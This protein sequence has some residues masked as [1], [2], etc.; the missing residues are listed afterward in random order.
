ME[1]LHQAIK[2]KKWDIR[3]I[4]KNLS[5][6]IISQN[7][8]ENQLQSLPDASAYAEQLNIDEL[9]EKIK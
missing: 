4:E 8:L 3:L 7:E 1:L 5:Q 2:S 9:V 6:G